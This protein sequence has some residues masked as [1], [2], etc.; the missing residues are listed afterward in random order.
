MLISRMDDLANAYIRYVTEVTHNEA[1]NY[2]NLCN[3]HHR[4]LDDL[5]KRISRLNDDRSST[6]SKQSRRSSKSRKSFESTSSAVQR[7]TEMMAKAAR[8][9]TELKFHEL[10]RER[11][12]VLEKQKNKL[13]RLQIMKE[14]AATQAEIEAVVQVE[15]GSNSGLN[16]TNIS[17]LVEDTSARERVEQYVK[18]QDVSNPYKGLPSADE[19]IDPIVV[20]SDDKGQPTFDDKLDRRQE[21]HQQS[22]ISEDTFK[23]VSSGR[24]APA[25][26]L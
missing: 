1:S 4:I 21:V 8:L 14:L 20:V 23:N 19:G 17:K 6:A 7:K 3:T 16:I 22:V 15:N 5:N 9:N 11:S 12:A 25:F 10:E 24:S 2:D 13:K 26:D 18:S